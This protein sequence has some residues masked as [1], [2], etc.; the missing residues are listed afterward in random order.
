MTRS[1]APLFLLAVGGTLVGTA[2]SFTYD[3]DPAQLSAR[4]SHKYKTPCSSWVRSH[5]TGFY[6]CA[7]P[8]V[9]LGIEGPKAPAPTEPA[10][11]LAALT[12][13]ASASTAAPTT[14][15]TDLDS[16]RKHGET[17]YNNVCAACHQANGQGIPGAFPPLAGAGAFYGTPQ[18]MARIVVHGLS[19]EITV[20]GQ[21]YNGA[22]PPQG[23]LSDYDIAAIT[24]YVR[25]S[26]GNDDGI[27]LPSDV[28]AVR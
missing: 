27:V 24:T 21:T 25:T 2:C 20:L 19:G 23:Y 28:A 14:G 15:P 5:V 16:L 18:N 17:Q 7:S 6:Y 10:K 1:F 8:V 12:A 11:A 22:M 9:D 26:F 13:V 3:K 4:Y